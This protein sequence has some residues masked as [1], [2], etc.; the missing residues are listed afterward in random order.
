MAVVVRMPK[1]GL[2]MVEGI[3]SEWL[4]AD[5]DTVAAGDLLVGVETAKINYQLEAAAGGTV[6]KIFAPQSEVVAV[7][8]ALCVIGEPD[9]ALDFDSL[10]ASVAV[11]DAALPGGFDADTTRLGAAGV[12]GTGTAQAAP[13]PVSVSGSGPAAE[14]AA[15]CPASAAPRRIKASPLARKLAESY[16]LDLTV[17]TGHG[18]SGRIEKKDV[19]EA[20]LAAAPGPPAGVLA[21]VIAAAV[22]DRPDIQ[23]AADGSVFTEVPLAFEVMRRA[24]TRAPLT[25]TM[26]RVIAGNMRRSKQ[27]AAH[28][29]M[30]VR[31]DVSDLVKLRAQLNDEG[32]AQRVTF[33]DL[34]L[35]AVARVLVDNPMMRSVIQGE[36]IITLNDID[37]S[38]A[39]HLGE[40][41]LIVP[42]IR[43][44]DRLSLRSI[45][46]ERTR[47][48][49]LGRAGRLGPD[50]M[51]GGCF[52]ITNMGAVYDL[53]FGTPIINLPQSA[54]LGMGSI[55]RQPVVIGD[56]I[57]IRPVLNL[58]LTIDH[59]VIDGEPAVRFL[60]Q[61]RDVLSNPARGFA[62]N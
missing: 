27:L 18:P 55:Q 29:T 31:A 62:L 17:I 2:S 42:V 13:A 45:S 22:P 8:G 61:V 38:L 12:F 25:G 14:P 28:A 41:G 46:A 44:C 24:P 33:T 9:E 16:G 50:D 19:E 60:N 7:G 30:S 34:F 10:G 47:L 23:S 49:E 36:E 5:G 26:R 37:V 35:K 6:R 59:R 20:R 48:T 4:V 1:L 52:T 53:D 58:F 21:P 3:V 39:V 54:I 43:D 11:P 56:E 15:G 51:V 40:T 32:H 57:A